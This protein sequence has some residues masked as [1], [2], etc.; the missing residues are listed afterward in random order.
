MRR[1]AVEQR[2]GGP[3]PVYDAGSTIVGYLKR[4]PAVDWSP[5]YSAIHPALGDQYIT[6]SKIEAT[7]LGYQVEGL[8]GYALDR[9]AD[10]PAEMFQKEIKWGS[11]FGQ[12]RRYIE[13]GAPD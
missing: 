8:L 7:D 13:G 1:L 3:S 4:S 6:R 9:P 12:R 11:R 2:E 10:Q 5:L